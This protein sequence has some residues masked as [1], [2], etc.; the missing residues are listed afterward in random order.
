MR[1]IV[2]VNV[3]G[4]FIARI[5]KLTS[6]SSLVTTPVDVLKS[7]CFHLFYTFLCT[8]LTLNLDKKN[9]L[10]KLLFTFKVKTVTPGKTYWSMLCLRTNATSLTIGQKEPYIYSCTLVYFHPLL[11]CEIQ[12]LSKIFHDINTTATIY[13]YALK[14]RWKVAIVH[15]YQSCN[16]TK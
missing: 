4:L 13:N 2:R 16:L 3:K 6:T 11:Y 8:L 12:N 14:R 7:R 10:S 15:E 1:L 9:L 5:L